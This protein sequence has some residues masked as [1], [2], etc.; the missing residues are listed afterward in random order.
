V[1]DPDAR[2]VD[3]RRT[4]GND[5]HAPS[6][7]SLRNGSELLLEVLDVMIDRIEAVPPGLDEEVI[8]RHVERACSR[9]TGQA[10]GSY[11][12]DDEQQPCTPRQLV[13]GLLR[14]WAGD[15]D[16]DL[17]ELLVTIVAARVVRTTLSGG[18]GG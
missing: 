7:L 2:E 3:E 13:G 6:A 17:H 16:G 1:K 15:L 11:F 14:Q 5:Q 10:T 12:V 9:R 4:V 18:S 8:E